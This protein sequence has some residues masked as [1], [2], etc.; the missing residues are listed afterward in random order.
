MN[1]IYIH[2]IYACMYIV[3]IY[4]VANIYHMTKINIFL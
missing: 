1:R 3:Q 4:D 2:I